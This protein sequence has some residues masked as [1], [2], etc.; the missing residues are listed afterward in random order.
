MSP[1]PAGNAAEDAPQETPAGSLADELV[2]LAVEHS[3]P[4]T[5]PCGATWDLD[6]ALRVVSRVVAAETGE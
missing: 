1:S 3:T 2:L 4:V 5:C 6:R